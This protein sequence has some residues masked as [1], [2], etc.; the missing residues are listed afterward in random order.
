MIEVNGSAANI[1]ANLAGTNGGTFNIAADGSMNFDPG[2]DFDYLAMGE[3]VVTTVTYT[4]TDGLG[5]EAVGLET[6]ERGRDAAIKAK[7][8][9]LRKGALLGGEFGSKARTRENS[10]VRLQ[11]GAFGLLDH[12]L[13]H[14][15][16]GL[17][18]DA[19]G[20]DDQRHTD[21]DVVAQRVL[22]QLE[23][24]AQAGAVRERQLAA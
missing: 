23:W 6:D 13:A 8:M 1:G 20:A 15:A 22:H 3:T 19:L 16:G 12:D 4:I 18:L 5:L 11:A 17:L 21:R 24:L 9:D 14:S 2:S 7:V 10:E